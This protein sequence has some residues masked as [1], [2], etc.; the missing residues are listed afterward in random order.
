MRIEIEDML[1]EAKEKGCTKML[2]QLR[3]D[4][5]LFIKFL[6]SFC[7]SQVSCSKVLLKKEVWGYVKDQA[8]DTRSQK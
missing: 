8:A 5:P 3:V 4:C 2:I 7:T 6:T 1:Y